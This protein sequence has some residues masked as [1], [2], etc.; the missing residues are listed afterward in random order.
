M[1]KDLVNFANI[2]PSL[3]QEL[4]YEAF[5]CESEDEAR[6][7]M[8]LLSEKK[9]PV[10]V[11]KTE[12]SGEKLYEEF[13]TEEEIYSLNKFQALGVIDKKP[14]Y[15][16]EEMNKIILELKELLN[17]PDTIKSDIV[18]WLNKYIPE[19]EHNETGLSLDKKM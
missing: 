12:T 14:S 5:I 6:N 9:Y 18:L 11:F 4:G 15:T 19:F 1:N 8:H 7:S 17:K 13:Y 2:F 3:L 10:Y 16:I